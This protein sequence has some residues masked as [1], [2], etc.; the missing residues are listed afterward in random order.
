MHTKY[1]KCYILYQTDV[2]RNKNRERQTRELRG[3]PVH[4]EFFAHVFEYVDYKYDIV[5]NDC[6]YYSC[7]C[8]KSDH[9]SI[10]P[11]NVVSM[12]ILE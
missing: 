11:R 4:S 12:V 9:F 3:I 2:T 1:K 8:V 6:K 7:L 10:L 5:N